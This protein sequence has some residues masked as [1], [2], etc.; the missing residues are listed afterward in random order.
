MLQ[1]N[2][3]RTPSTVAEILRT[4]ATAASA[5]QQPNNDTGW[6]RVNALAAVRKAVAG[7]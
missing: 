3:R 2:P 6:G 1:A 5:A 4:S 7:G